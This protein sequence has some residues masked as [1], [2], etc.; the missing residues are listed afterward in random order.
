[1]KP[2]N[3]QGG[4]LLDDAGDARK[5][6]ATGLAFAAVVNVASDHGD[7]TLAAGL[8]EEN[9]IHGINLE[10]AD[11]IGADFAFIGEVANGL[12]DKGLSDVH[13][14]IGELEFGI[15]D[16]HCFLKLGVL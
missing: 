8:C 10:S 11:S 3:P 15:G 5:L 2:L 1:M 9:V 12:A 6:E 4:K 16:V 13:G 7:A 14:G